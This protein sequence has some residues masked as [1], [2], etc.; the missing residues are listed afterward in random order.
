[1][2]T[3][4]KLLTER[5]NTKL[6]IDEK[7]SRNGR[8]VVRGEFAA[9]D[10]PTGNKRVYERALLKRE[11]SKIQEDVKRRRVLGE[12]DHPKDGEGSL[13]HVSHVV[14]GL[15]LRE[16]GVVE[17]EAE[18]LNTDCGRNLAEIL[19]AGCEVGVSSRG[20]GTTM[21]IEGDVNEKVSDDYRLVTFDFVIDPADKNAY[22]QMVQESVQR[23]GTPNEGPLEASLLE[24]AERRGAARGAAETEAVLRAKLTEELTELVE[25][26]DHEVTERVRGEAKL[27]FEALATLTSFRQLLAPT[28]LP[29]DYQRVVDTKQAEALQVTEKL[30]T[31]ERELRAVSDSYRTL[32]YEHFVVTSVPEAERAAVFE[33]LGDLAQF[34]T[35]DDFRARFDELRHEIVEAARVERERTLE[36]E[37]K[38]LRAKLSS[39]RTERSRSQVEIHMERVLGRHP[40][41]ERLRR[42]LQAADPQTVEAVDA[43]VEEFDAGQPALSSDLTERMRQT[44]GR[45]VVRGDSSSANG[46]RGDYNGLGISLTDVRRMAGMK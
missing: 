28:F 25:R 37:N 45:G 21:A 17:G 42:V 19:K 10:R 9:A 16:D 43:I 34:P 12:A 29:T 30:Q 32:V 3:V 20:Y 13:K 14:T 40:R 7:Q 22:P 15:R 4:L 27:A 8:L 18:I 38:T 23:A 26:V 11:V 46:S 5:I 31:T 35:A 33:A 39:T 44:I 2:A 24:E 36:E 6:T 41:E 1:M